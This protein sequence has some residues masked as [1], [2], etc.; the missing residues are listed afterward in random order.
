MLPDNGAHDVGRAL[1]RRGVLRL[2]AVA[3]VVHRF[4]GAGADFES[5]DA[6][7]QV[8]AAAAATDAG[9]AVTD[10]AQAAANAAQAAADAAPPPAT[11]AAVRIAATTAAAG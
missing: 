5:L 2:P 3:P 4:P 10:A 1:I 11:A 7:G 8:Q 9:E 6:A